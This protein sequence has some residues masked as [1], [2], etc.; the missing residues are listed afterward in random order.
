MRRHSDVN[1]KMKASLAVCLLSLFAVSASGADLMQVYRDALD[2]DARFAAARAQLEAGQEKV[3]QGRAGLLPQLGVSAD[4]SW[5]DNEVKTKAGT[6]SGDFQRRGYGVQLTQPLFDRQSWVQFRQGELQT[7]LA[8]VQFGLEQQDLQL[9]VAEAYF[10]VLNAQDAVDVVRQLRE[11]AAEQLELARTSFEVGT[12]TITDVHEAQ[13]RFDLASAQEIAAQSQLEVMRQMLAQIIGYQPE[14]LAGLREGLVLEHPQP[15][16]V[17]A[18]VQAAESDNLGVHAQQLLQEMAA[19]EI[20][21]ARAGHLPRVDLVASHGKSHKPQL[22]T[23]RSEASMIGVQLN[24][25]LYAGGRV[26]SV[27]REAAAMRMKADAELDDARR[28]A[29]LAAHQSWL[30]VT[31][32][33][34]EVK[35]L[36]A[37]RLSSTSALDAN[38]LGYEVGVRIN[39]DVLN[40]QAQL[41]DTLQKL[42]RARYDTLIAQ[43]RLKAAAGELGEDDLQTINRFLVED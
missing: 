4:A 15:A 20:E 39:I 30:G 32:G 9:R 8:G 26:S 29:V 2:H 14:R 23:Q 31:S 28:S 16:S 5:N 6:S 38:K 1:M 27:T 21:R 19:R 36:E 3:I 42:S 34:A 17:D 40:A 7:A 11:A 33:M 41:A 18:W 12:V 35:A 25:P 22:G 13:S 10:N 43:L 37:A 24:L